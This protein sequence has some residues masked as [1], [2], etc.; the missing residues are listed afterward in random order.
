MSV[1]IRISYTTE[2]ELDHMIRL[3][4]PQIRSWKASKTQKGEYKHA[5]VEMVDKSKR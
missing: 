3:L 5:Y 4:S 2:E 1:K